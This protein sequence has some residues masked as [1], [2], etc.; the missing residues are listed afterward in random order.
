MGQVD[1]GPSAAVNP[2]FTEI[3]DR[4]M[5]AKLDKTYAVDRWTILEG[6]L[7]QRIVQDQLLPQRIADDGTPTVTHLPVGDDL[8]KAFREGSLKNLEM[9]VR[10]GSAVT[11]DLVVLSINGTSP[12]DLKPL[13][14]NGWAKLSPAAADFRQGSNE[15]SL[16][17]A[18]RGE[19]GE[20]PMTIEAV[21]LDVVYD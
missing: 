19:D 10:L 12:I 8:A 14:E 1:W 6:D 7:A 15:L 20:M 4:Q 9:R 11:G 18:R 21:G 16:R 3:G 5:L 2:R 17:V 13:D